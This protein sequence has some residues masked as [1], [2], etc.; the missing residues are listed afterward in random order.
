MSKREMETVKTFQFPL[1]CTVL[2]P[3]VSSLSSSEFYFYPPIVLGSTRDLGMKAQVSVA[4]VVIYANRSY[5]LL[6]PPPCLLPSTND[7]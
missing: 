5:T 6:L 1:S 7:K 3:I 4:N 2:A